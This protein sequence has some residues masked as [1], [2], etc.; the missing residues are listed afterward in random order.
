VTEKWLNVILDLNGVL[1]VCE[2]K[3]SLG[4]D[5]KINEVPPG[6]EVFL[7][8]MK[9]VALRPFCRTFLRELSSIANVHV[10]SSM[11]R[12]NILPVAEHLFEGLEQPLYVLGQEQCNILKC[13]NKRGKIVNYKVKGTD[14]D[15]FL[16]PLDKLFELQDSI[17][18]FQ[19]TIIVD[20][21]PMKHV[22]NFSWSVL[23]FETWSY[24]GEGAMD[25]N[26]MGDI[27]P[28]IRRLH[29]SKPESLSTFR[30]N[31]KT[32]RRHLLQEQDGAEYDELTQAVEESNSIYDEW[33]ANNP[34]VV[35]MFEESNRAQHGGL[36]FHSNE[37]AE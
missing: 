35:M 23:L 37:G 3:R 25:E 16:K 18:S 29:L 34:N 10:W 13:R 9:R 19:N 27:L 12:S 4:R 8:G 24:K 22:T 32:G 11:K 28:W 36:E 21:S 15:L 6:I 1:C 7:T 26:L 20:D 30:R 5:G 33:K 14:K 2:D 31:N 17:F